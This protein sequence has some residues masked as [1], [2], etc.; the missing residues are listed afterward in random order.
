MFAHWIVALF[1]A[2][3]LWIIANLPS[4]SFD[5]PPPNSPLGQTPDDDC[6]RGAPIWHVDVRNLNLVVTDTPFWV[7]SPSGYD[8][9]FNLTYNVLAN[10]D[11]DSHVGSRW[12]HTY[13][14]HIEFDENGDILLT[15]N[16][17][18]VD[19]YKKRS[20]D[21]YQIPSNL[22]L[23]GEA[24]NSYYIEKTDQGFKLIKPN[25]YY[26]LY[27]SEI[28]GKHYITEKNSSNGLVFRVNYIENSIQYVEDHLGRRVN[29][30][31]IDNKITQVVGPFGRSANLTYDIDG[32]LTSITDMEGYKSEFGYEDR[33]YLSYIENI[34][35]KTL[36]YLEIGDESVTRDSVYPA[37]GEELGNSVRLTITDPDNNKS[38]YFYNSANGST[39]Y[40]APEH[41]KPYLGPDYNNYNFDVPKV[42]YSYKRYSN[43]YSK[44]SK[45][46]YQDDTWIRLNYGDNKYLS[47]KEYSDGRVEKYTWS[48][49]GRLSSKTNTN[50]VETTYEYD[51]SVNILSVSNGLITETF[52]YD[53]KGQV[54]YRDNGSGLTTTIEYN[55]DGNPKKISTSEGDVTEYQYDLNGYL[56][57]SSKNGENLTTLTRDSLGRVV[58][59]TD[60]IGYSTHFS[61]NDIDT[62]I[63]VRYPGERVVE[64]EFG[65]C[66]R[67]LQSKTLPMGRQTHYG[68]DNNKNL[69]EVRRADDSEINLGRDKSGRLI[70]LTDANQNT[71]KFEYSDTGK[72]LKKTYADG[73]QLEMVYRQGRVRKIVNARGIEKR[74]TYNDLG[75]LVNIDYSDDT[76][77][78]SYTYDVFGRIE[79]ATDQFGTTTYSFTNDGYLSGID[80]PL[81]QD[82]IEIKYSLQRQVTG[83]FVNGKENAIYEYDSLG[84]IFRTTA[85]GNAFQYYYNLSGS[86]PKIVLEYPNGIRKESTINSSADL[87]QIKYTLNNNVIADYQYGYNQAGQVNSQVGTSEFYIPKNIDAEYNNLN[88]FTKW[89]GHKGLFEYDRDGNPIKGMLDDDTY[90]EA[91]YDAENRL[92]QIDFQKDGV[93]YSERFGYDHS[94]MLVQ[95]ELI[96]DGQIERIKRF[97]RL[98]LVELQQRDEKGNIDSEFSWALNAPGG[99]G[100]LLTAKTNSVEH[101]YVY[102]NLGNVQKVI[103]KEGG[104]VANYTYSAFGQSELSDF[105]TQSFGYSNKRSDFE[106]GLVYFGYR[107]YSPYQQRWLNRDPL[108]EQGGIN[109]YK[110]IHGD[111]INLVDPNGLW[112][113]SIS[114]YN[115]IGLG[116][117]FGYN[118]G[119]G[120]YFGKLH[121]G[122]GVEGGVGFDPFEGGDEDKQ[123]CGESGWS[124]GIEADWSLNYGT[125]GVGGNTGSNFNTGEAGNPG[126]L[127]NTDGKFNGF[128]KPGKIGGGIHTGIYFDFFF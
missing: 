40:T 55:D 42:T 90:Y 34:L 3:F 89:Q 54:I 85:L 57:G 100:G 71:T 39:Y 118:P 13:G 78:V 60:Y 32:N 95:Y 25:G 123:N 45:I 74:L 82:N 105:S 48:D 127:F 67:L 10:E 7:N 65:A 114:W 16:S 91:V 18:R 24:Q 121:F 72:L 110:Y 109:L 128:D 88:Q 87:S 94:S 124:S 79:T 19:L 64:Y 35:G 51:E 75:Q 31:Y 97:V 17:G 104:L 36:F 122:L 70:S 113:V 20:D 33:G 41:Y 9:E 47:T 115:G 43:S 1:I 4:C 112:A 26:S 11:E 80:G 92:V 101:Y 69:T 107:F 38:E 63:S 117:E 103:D 76:P 106:S 62:L 56:V 29:F 111:P 14:S 83:I 49:N 77:P 46:D 126:D 99:I 44:I 61:Y 102:N 120:K 30:T 125:G 93:S 84:R 81:A 27:Q 108:Q 50:G 22:K 66:P 8:I 53:D 119:T 6:E 116:G 59:A 58:T 37:P 98:G 68:Y 52:R 2:I 23:E 12:S 28:D 86:N 73:S 21:T 5:E 15:L 96:K